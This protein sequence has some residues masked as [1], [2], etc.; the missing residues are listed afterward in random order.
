M[1][2][3]DASALVPLIT[4]EASSTAMRLRLSEDREIMVWWSTEIE[5]TS[6]V[7]RSARDG[8][9]D[10]QGV[11]DA[12]GRLADLK[13]EWQETQPVE[14]VRVTARRLLATHPLRAADAQQLAAAI[15]AAEGDPRSLVMVTL[16]ERL[17]E[18]ARREG[19]EVVGA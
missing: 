4:P 7:H 3:W 12:L 14:A 16:D 1:K 19:L 17:G 13:A 11:A 18:A 10:A 5:C 2:F 9:L 6:A 8:R 15:V